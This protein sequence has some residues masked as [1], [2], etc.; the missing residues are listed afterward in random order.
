MDGVHVPVL[1]EQ[2]VGA[3]APARGGTF[4]D[5]TFGAGGHSRELLS[6][7][8]PAGRLLAVD[9]D[10][11]VAEFATRISDRRFSFVHG[12]FCRLDRIAADCGISGAAGIIM[13]LGMSSMQI[14]DTGRGLSFAAAGPLD[15]RLDPDND[16][17]L[18]DWLR[19]AS[20][21]EIGRV[22]RQFGEER[23]W[24]SI[25]AAIA[26]RRRTRRL[27]DTADLVAAVAAA[28]GS[29]RGRI[30]PATRTFQALRIHVNRELTRLEAGLEA[31]GRLLGKGGRIV[32]IS[33]HSLEDRLVRDFF[34]GSNQA[35]GGWMRIIRLGRPTPKEEEDNPRSRSARLRAFERL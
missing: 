10:P 4:I 1:V 31:A 3:L 34:V 27:A 29:R 7:L 35:D 23:N 33:F 28:V 8:P 15:M 9:C 19:T 22:I 16:R 2:A 12:N 11:T 13:D 25:A 17:P 26:E 14:A 32:V 20:E 5:A 24:R 21:R 18:S 30:H 6:R